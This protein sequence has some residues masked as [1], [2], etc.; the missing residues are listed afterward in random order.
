MIANAAELLTLRG[1]C[2]A[3]V[4]DEMSDLS[5]IRDGAVYIRDG[6]IEAVGD[7]SSVLRD[8]DARGI[9]RIDASGRVVMPGFV[10]PH[11]HLVFA[12][13][14]EHELDMKIKG[15]SYKDILASGGGILRT[16]AETRRHLRTNCS[17]SLLRVSGRC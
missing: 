14:R 13:S 5:I 17:S 4:R 9:E 7:S 16:V 11:T 8:N 15:M 6:I 10:D 12:G 3:R 1:P 2:R